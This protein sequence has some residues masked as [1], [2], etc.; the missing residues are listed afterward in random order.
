MLIG[1]FTYVTGRDHESRDQPCQD[2]VIC[3]TTA[4]GTRSALVLC[5]GAGSCIRSEIGA[6]YLCDW[7]PTWVDE[8]QVEFWTLL[9]AELVARV[10]A[11]ISVRLEALAAESA[12]LP[13]DLSSTFMAVVVRRLPE[14]LDY[15]IFHLGDG[16]IAGIGS[17]GRVVLSAP[18]NGEFANE[19]VFTTCSRFSESLRVIAGELPLGS[20]FVAMSDGSGTSLYL[21]AR[22]ALAP[23]VAEM[24]AW[25]NENDSQTVSTAIEQNMRELL[26]SK[27]GDDCSLGLLLDRDPSRPFAVELSHPQP[28]NLQLQ[29]APMNIEYVTLG[30]LP[31]EFLDVVMREFI[32][33]SVGIGRVIEGDASSF[34]PLGTGTLVRRQGR[35]GILT[36]Y[37][38]LHSCS[39]QVSVGLSGRDTLTLMLR[40]GRIVMLRP[41]EIFEHPLAV[42]L[43]D[44][45][46]PDLTFLEIAPGSKLESILAI[47]SVWPLDRDQSELLNTFGSTGALLA[48]IG[49]PEVECYTKIHG[50]DIHRKAM[51]KTFINVIEDKSLQSKD[52]W[53]YVDVTCDYA[54]TPDLP[55]SFRGLSGGGI[56]SMQLRK[57][58]SDGHISIERSALVG[59]TF[60]QGELVNQSRILRGHFIR[61]IYDVAWRGFT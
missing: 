26:C 20:G 57:H 46:G 60:Y 23:A 17:D 15:R 5:D 54:G 41:E 33:Y 4:D 45:Y 52:G 28:E 16:I 44:E 56:W 59:V 27:T 53:D 8:A 7:F 6:Q 12:C 30:V 2:R 34:R 21:K 22:Q 38:C 50:N 37:H 24:L 51:H 31:P 40:G 42:P 35:I 36:A 61:S 10:S 39:P 55:K 25:L 18:D 32:P 58:K 14:Q 9:P 43:R 11:E 47:S 29:T 48:S 1:A 13:H 3:R 19:T 49:F